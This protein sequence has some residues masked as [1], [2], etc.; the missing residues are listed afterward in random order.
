MSLNTPFTDHSLRELMLGGVAG[1][2]AVLAVHQPVLIA[3]DG[4]GVLEFSGY[5]IRPTAPF[6]VPQIASWC[7][8]GGVWGIIFAMT[9]QHFP[10]GVWYWIAVFVAGAIVLPLVVW[11]VVQ[12]LRGQP[13]G[14]G[15]ETA[16]TTAI[17]FV[18]GMWALG[19]AAILKMLTRRP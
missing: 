11:F 15:W 13:I 17:I 7:F 14:G 9:S 1:A 8:W 16:R 5:P 6:G 2:L 4:M 18:H 10:S 19:T 12:P 3:L